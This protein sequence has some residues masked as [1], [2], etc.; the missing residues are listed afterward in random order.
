MITLHL[1]TIPTKIVKAPGSLLMPAE[2]S[3]FLSR[4]LA[5]GTAFLM[6]HA[7]YFNPW[8][9]ESK[10]VFAEIGNFFGQHLA[11]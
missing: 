10:E 1:P 6:A 3:L 7:Q 8:L 11:R 4:V 2:H 5:A 9:P